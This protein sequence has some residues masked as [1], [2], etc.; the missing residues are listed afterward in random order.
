[1]TD[2]KSKWDIL[3]LFVLLCSVT[4]WKAPAEAAE[5]RVEDAKNA[6]VEVQTGLRSNDG[7]FY[8]IKSASGFVISN[9]QGSVY[10]VTTN[11][12]VT[13]E[14]S[15]KKKAYKTYKLGKNAA[16]LDTET[17]I[18]IEGDVASDV[19]VKAS[20]KTDDFCI[21]EA[22]NVLN[23]KKPLCLSDEG[24]MSIGDAVFI[25]G[26]PA[27][28]DSEKEY[29]SRD[30]EIHAGT[31]QDTAAPVDGNTYIQHS[32]VI[33]AEQ[34][35]SALIDQQGYLAGMGNSAVSNTG[36][37]VYYALPIGKI[38][39]ILDN[40]G[41]NYDSK[42]KQNALK[43]LQKTYEK[44]QQ[45]S[46]SGDYKMDSVEDLEPA[47]QNAKETMAKEKMTVDEIISAQKKLDQAES[48]LEKKTSKLKIIK[49]VL[50]PVIAVMVILAVQSALSYR[51]IKRRAAQQERAEIPVRDEKAVTD[52]KPPVEDEKERYIDRGL[53]VPEF[54]GGKTVLMRQDTNISGYPDEKKQD[55]LF[56]ANGAY[57]VDTNTGGRHYIT[58]K[59][60]RIGKTPDNDYQILKTTVSRKHAVILWREGSYYI[61]D[62]GSVNGTYVNGQDVGKGV[63]LQNH[64]IVTL[65]K[66]ELEFIVK[67]VQQNGI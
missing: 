23:K 42:K 32:A 27:K 37:G 36:I 59:L 55:A 7:K 44:C 31:V 43:T 41:I 40:Y 38:Q 47:L 26:F 16:E 8:G 2:T 54:S 19:T 10:I 13:V 67:E 11:H 33:L 50:L 62:Q 52:E 17:R 53:I 39:P 60:F 12:S 66:E 25:L 65:A 51:R 49:F 57:L 5:P 24:E 56:H 9:E 1:M 20:S 34:S 48:K 18:L 22:G 30:V 4:V 46:G 61:R 64:D 58:S 6:I 3:F 45:I 63:K 29:G 21:L 35:G 15:E 14:K 28:K